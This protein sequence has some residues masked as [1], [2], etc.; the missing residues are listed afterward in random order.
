[1]I[2]A[3]AFNIGD[4]L[5]IGDAQGRSLTYGRLAQAFVYP[6]PGCESLLDASDYTEAFDPAASQEASSLREYTYAKEVHPTSLN[7]E[8]LRFYH[9]FGLGRSQ[10]ALMPDHLAVELEFMQFLSALEVKALERGED[11]ASLERAQRDFMF[12]HLRVLVDGIA[13]A[14]K[15]IAPPPCRALVEMVK[16]VVN[17]DLVRL[18][19]AAGLISGLAV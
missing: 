19:N 16:E 1:M 18:N 7:E 4:V 6:Q 11:I 17:T 5:N 13:N 12:R 3:D 14:Q 10:Q 15:D 8:L 2:S 9:F